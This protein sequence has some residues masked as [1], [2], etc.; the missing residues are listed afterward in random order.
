MTDLINQK[1]E[2]SNLIVDLLE[3]ESEEAIRTITKLKKQRKLIE[4]KISEK[5]SNLSGK[6]DMSS[7]RNPSANSMTLI[8]D[9]ARLEATPRIPLKRAI[10]PLILQDSTTSNRFSAEMPKNNDQTLSS[11]DEQK[12][13]RFPDPDHSRSTLSTLSAQ[14]HQLRTPKTPL[15]NFT[16]FPRI[17]PRISALDAVKN[18]EQSLKTYYHE[19][20][21]SHWS[22][23]DFPWTRNVQKAIKLYRGISLYW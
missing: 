9:I 20:D 23:M 2:I 1:N 17:S 5:S 4:Q 21:M 8:S 16:P 18:P 15:R 3:D 6:Q 22:R 7:F 19:P 12:E 11:V 13:N 10:P 14:P